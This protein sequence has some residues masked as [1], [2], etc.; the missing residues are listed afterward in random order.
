MFRAA[1]RDR[2]GDAELSQPLPRVRHDLQ[3]HA[4]PPGRRHRAARRA[5][6]RPDDRDRR[7]QQQQHLQPGAD[8]RRDGC[9]PTTSPTR[10]A[11]LSADGHPAQAGRQ[12][13]GDDDHRAGCLPGGWS[14]GLT[15]G[16]STPDNLVE[17]RHPTALD[18]VSD[19]TRVPRGRLHSCEVFVAA[20]AL[21]RV[22]VCLC[23]PDSS[24][25]LLSAGR[26]RRAVSYESEDSARAVWPHL[27]AVLPVSWRR[28]RQPAQGFK[29]WQSEQYQ[30]RARPHA[31]T[32][33][34][35][36]GYLPGGRAGAEG[37]EEGARQAETEFERLVERGDDGAVMEQVERRRGGARRAE[38]VAH[39][40]AA[41]MRRVLT[42]DQW[43]K[44]S[45]MH[46]AARARTQPTETSAASSVD[47][48]S[49]ASDLT[50]FTRS[51]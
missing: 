44:F 4:G 24:K 35:A 46:Q 27:L 22:T 8:L 20:E 39:D 30:A 25:R 37:A 2:Y 38:Q 43:A 36:R 6:A 48:S 15:S 32:E 13:A 23:S 29:W 33:P 49:T 11:L 47:R 40:D 42:T 18:D 51:P 16:A 34:A 12:Q 19:S 26:I 9:R 7:L 10:T 50:G 21:S 45:A 1:M 5:A 31:G 28:R 14:I 17:R 41:P 3:R